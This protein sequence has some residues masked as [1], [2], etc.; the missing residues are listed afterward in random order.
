MQM[1]PQVLEDWQARLIA[2]LNAA[3]KAGKKL[4]AYVRV[5]NKTEKYGLAGADEKNLLVALQGN[6]L[7]VS[8]K[9][10]AA[11]DRIAVAKALL[12]GDDDVPGLLCV[13]V[14]LLSDGQTSQGEEYLAKATLK[15]AKAAD[16]FK[17]S[18]ALAQ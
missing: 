2:R 18:L 3:V 7:P 1:P 6:A 12:E 15:N 14:F 17:I 11:T 4:A 5:G 10:L 9:N 8:W 16:E 13:S